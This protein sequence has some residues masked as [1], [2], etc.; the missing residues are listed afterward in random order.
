MGNKAQKPKDLEHQQKGQ[1]K[2]RQIEQ[3]AAR[4]VKYEMKTFGLKTTF[5]GQ[6][7]AVAVFFIGLFLLIF[8]LIYLVGALYYG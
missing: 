7:T 3:A 4:Q 5:E 2:Q 8:L 1:K 6:Q